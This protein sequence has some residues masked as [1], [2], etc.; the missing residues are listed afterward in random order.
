MELKFIVEAILFCSDKPLSPKEIRGILDTAAKGSD[1]E[2]VQYFKKTK[3]ADIEASLKAL[4]EDHAEADRSYRL[5]CMAGAWQ[6]VTQPDYA[7][8]LRSMLGKR[9]R[10][11][12]LSQPALETL[13]IVAYRQPLTRSE[14]EQIRGVSVDGVIQTLV[15]RELI[16]PVGRADVA[17]RPVT[18][19]TTTAFLDYFGLGSLEDLPEAE[20]LKRIPTGS[21]GQAETDSQSQAQSGADS[22]SQPGDQSGAETESG[23]SSGES[24]NSESATAIGEAT[25]SDETGTEETSNDDGAAEETTGEEVISEDEPTSEAGDQSGAEQAEGLAQSWPEEELPEERPDESQA[26]ETSHPPESEDH[27]NGI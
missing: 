14:M 20:E 12:R 24:P 21:A 11:S 23:D 13:A 26:A 10:S 9:N 8:W 1:D 18:Y 2:A 17:G 27:G 19:G 3:E 6:F 22:E 16:E 25:T 5:H 4:Q 15:D 7:P